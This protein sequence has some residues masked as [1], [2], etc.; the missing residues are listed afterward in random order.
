LG[1]D[2]LVEFIVEN[3]DRTCIFVDGNDEDT[4]QEQAVPTENNS[5][6]GQ[7]SSEVVPE[8]LQSPAADT[9]QT[10]S[11]AENSAVGFSTPQHTMHVDDIPHHHLLKV[12]SQ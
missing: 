8:L 7:G 1:G 11:H 10:I 5:A 3:E 2:I 4:Q 9:M 6:T 12:V